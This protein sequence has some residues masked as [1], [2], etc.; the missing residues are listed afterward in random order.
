MCECVARLIPLFLDG[1]GGDGEIDGGGVD[2]L[3]TPLVI[4]YGE[5]VEGEVPLERDSPDAPDAPVL[6]PNR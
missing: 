1:G 4:A 5:G 6:L 3:C 2:I